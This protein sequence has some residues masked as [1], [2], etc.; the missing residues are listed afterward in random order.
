ME[1]NSFRARIDRTKIGVATLHR[2]IRTAFLGI[3]RIDGTGVVIVTRDHSIDTHAFGAG[4]GGTKI[5]VVAVDLGVGTTTRRARSTNYSIDGTRISVVAREDG[6]GDGQR[7]TAYGNR[8][9][10][11]AR[12][13]AEA[14]RA[15][16]FAGRAVNS[17][18]HSNND[19]GFFS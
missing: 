17:C 15:R 18:V 10:A 14:N 2:C 7:Y 1:A 13:R 16:S 5:F 4:V 19:G 8:G 9:G 12:V 11:S 3:A 6:T